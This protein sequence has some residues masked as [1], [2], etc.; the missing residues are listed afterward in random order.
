MGT[1][2]GATL[3]LFGIS[4]VAI[5]LGHFV[6]GPGVIPA[7]VP[8]N[9]TM[10]SEDRFYAVFFL[11]YGA[12]VLWCLRDWTSKLREILLLMALFLIAGLTRLISI[13]AVGLPHAFFVAMTIIE[14]LVPPLVIF[15]SSRAFRN[16][17]AGSSLTQ[18]RGAPRPQPKVL[19]SPRTL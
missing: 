17:A 11:A 15:L 10:D 2:L 8:V 9:A 3:L 6:L 12:T 4:V 7:S 5:S 18:P 16:R 19:S 1:L 13:A 14:F